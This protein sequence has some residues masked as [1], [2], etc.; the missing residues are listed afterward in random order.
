LVEG[1][2][3]HAVASRFLKSRRPCCALGWRKRTGDP[4]APSLT[5]PP[6]A[7]ANLSQQELDQRTESQA[8]EQEQ[9]VFERSVKQDD[10]LFRLQMV[11]GWS[12][13]VIFPTTLMALIVYPPVGAALVPLLGA[14]VWNWRRMLARSGGKR[15]VITKRKHDRE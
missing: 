15:A 8:L 9:T 14:A 13:V 11:M 2:K 6:D 7:A 12:T 10:A 5:L 1:F 3:P 4:A